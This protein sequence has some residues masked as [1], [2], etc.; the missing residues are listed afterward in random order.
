MANI[1]EMCFGMIR[2]CQGATIT[3]IRGVEVPGIVFWHGSGS[4]GRNNQ[5]DSWRWKPENDVLARVRIFTRLSL[6]G[7]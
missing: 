1:P 4:S 2:Q 3:L 5:V 7:A 6:N